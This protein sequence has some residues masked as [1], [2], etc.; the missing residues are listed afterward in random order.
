MEKNS[1]FDNP[2]IRAARNSMTPEQIE[3]YKKIGEEYYKNIDM[4][5]QDR[6]NIIKQDSIY[7]KSVE[8][9]EDG[10]R[11]GL[12]YNDLEDDEKEI[13]KTKYGE[14]WYEHYGFKL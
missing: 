2:M 11:S 8:Y 13:L 4:T 9:I 7:I 10:I 14:K 6:K 5:E 3:L 1:I 12:D